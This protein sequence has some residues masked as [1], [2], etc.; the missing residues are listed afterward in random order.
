MWGTSKA[1]QLIPRAAVQK[2]FKIFDY[3][4]GSQKRKA[5]LQGAEAEY[6]EHPVPIQK[7]TLEIYTPEGVTSLVARAPS[8]WVDRS[9]RVAFSPGAIT[10]SLSD[11]QFTLTGVG[12]SWSV[13]NS[14]L[15]VSNRVESL[16]RGDLMTQTL[17]R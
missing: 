8:C 4:P 11:G 14:T 1:A 10:L 17:P 5:L 3:H 15:I 6:L 16:I 7:M 9:N 2:D 13:T 12:F